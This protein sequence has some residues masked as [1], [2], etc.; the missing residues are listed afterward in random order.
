LSLEVDVTLDP[1]AS[2]ADAA[3]AMRAVE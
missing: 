3:H 1:K 2:L